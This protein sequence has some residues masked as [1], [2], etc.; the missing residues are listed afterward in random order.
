MNGT[1]NRT[2]HFWGTVAVILNIGFIIA[3]SWLRYLLDSDKQHLAETVARTFGNSTPQSLVL[4]TVLLIPLIFLAFVIL[5]GVLWIM[6]LVHAATKPIREKT[7]WIMVL[8]FG[9]VF[10]GISYYFRVKR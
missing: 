5:G 6:M 7:F 2:D 8:V 3:Y 9:G 10:G 1:Q 4:L